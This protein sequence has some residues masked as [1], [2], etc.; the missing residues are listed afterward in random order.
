MCPDIPDFD[1]NGDDAMVYNNQLNQL[2]KTL[3][4][5]AS[6]LT[7]HVSNM[8][9]NNC[10]RR[11]SDDVPPIVFNSLAQTSTRMRSITHRKQSDSCVCRRFRRIAL[12]MLRLWTYVC[13]S[14]PLDRV[15]AF[16]TRSIHCEPTIVIDWWCVKRGNFEP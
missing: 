1:M 3:T 2:R 15:R 5:N 7:W 10:S 4:D 9:N 13:L 8:P 6:I 16:L 11:V 14:F 12:A